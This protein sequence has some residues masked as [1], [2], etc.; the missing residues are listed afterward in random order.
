MIARISIIE[1]S[2]SSTN[3]STRNNEKKVMGDSAL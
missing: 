3:Y 1:V 2:S